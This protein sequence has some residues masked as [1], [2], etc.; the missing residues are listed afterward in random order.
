MQQIGPMLAD[1]LFQI[2]DGAGQVSPLVFQSS[3]N[4]R[5]GHN[6]Y[7]LENKELWSSC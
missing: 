5:F 6:L 3:D 7:S 4:M 1:L 2:S